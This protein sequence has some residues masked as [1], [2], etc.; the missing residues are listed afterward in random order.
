MEQQFCKI[1]VFFKQEIVFR[2]V[3]KAQDAQVLML[4]IVSQMFRLKML[5]FRRFKIGLSSAII[6][7]NPSLLKNNLIFQNMSIIDCVSLKNQIVK[8]QFISQGNKQNF[9][10]FVDLIIY[11]SQESWV[12][13]F[14]NIGI[15]SESEIQE[16]TGKDNAIIYSENCDVTIE[17]VIFEG[18]LFSSVINLNNINTLNMVNCQF[19]NVQNI[20][21]QN[22][23]VISQLVQ[24]KY[25]VSLRSLNFK[26]GSMYS[27]NKLPNQ[28]Y[29]QIQI[30]YFFSGCSIQSFQVQYFQKNYFYSN[31]LQL[32]QQNQQQS[33]ILYIKGQ[34][35]LGVFI[36]DRIQFTNNNYSASQ[37]GIIH[38]DDINFKK[39]QIIRFDCHS[40]IINKYGCLNVIGNQNA[41]NVF[42][43]E[44]SNFISNLGTSGVAIKSSDILLKLIQCNI[45]FNI[46]LSQ[47]GALYLQ[48]NTKRFFIS[49]TIII[50]NKAQEGG[51]IYYDLDDD[52][53]IKTQVQTF[54]NFN[55][56]E[57]YGNNLVENP[58][59]LSLYINSK[60]MAALEYTINN[61]STSILRINPYIVLEQGIKRQTEMLMIPSSQVIYIQRE[62]YSIIFIIQLV[63]YADYTVIKGRD[64]KQNSSSKQLLQFQTE[65]NN[66]ELNTLSFRL[67]PY[68]KDS[69]HLQIQIFCKTQ[70]SQNGINYIINAKSFKCQLGEFYIED[71]C[72]TCKS[73]QG[74]YSVT[75]DTIKCSVFDK[76]KFQNGYWRPN[77]LSDATEEC[78]KNTEFC[79]EGWQVVDS[80]CSQGHIV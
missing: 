31:I 35:N 48:I 3:L 20:Y 28:E 47:G 64:E 76:T 16:I 15:L 38:I 36:F 9:I 77:Y 32:L 67:D 26:N 69:R 34:S 51:G 14:Q 75:Y 56:A 55:Q 49:K 12:N 63:Q 23:I 10:S 19:Q 68:Q 61:I 13:L 24:Q 74:F 65:N 40:N 39:F 52:L 22:L 79:L 46:A 21:T 17:N 44:N 33:S 73:S 71:G 30:N 45:M 53:S 80:T 27:A 4:Q 50:Y 8:V 72:Q 29:L 43:I 66:F 78:Y 2:K 37:Q 11:Q 42:K 57:V 7:I 58:S 18:M 5:N 59:Y 62:N 41:S 1:Y 70:K 6:T 54:I 60:E 25:Q